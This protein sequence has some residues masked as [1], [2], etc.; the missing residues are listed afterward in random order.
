MNAADP[1]GYY[2]ASAEP[3][4]EYPCLSGNQ[5]TDLCIIGAGYTGL[6]AALHA[7]RTGARTVVLESE[8]VGFGASGRN[9]GQIHSGHRIEQ[10]EL[11]Q[12]LG[13]QPAR[14][15]WKIS[16]VA[17]GLVTKLAAVNAPD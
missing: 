10:S 2:A 3:R 14:D 5:I 17:K 7:A 1:Q 6:S 12:W 4:T 13:T 9:G 15:L 8:M 16:E 11:E